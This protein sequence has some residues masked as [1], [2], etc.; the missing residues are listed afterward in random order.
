MA[1]FGV[2]SKIVLIS[3]GTEAAEQPLA[4]PQHHSETKTNKPFGLMVQKQIQNLIQTLDGEE[5]TCDEKLLIHILDLT[6]GVLLIAHTLEDMV[7][8]N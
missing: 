4:C 8:S 3:F 6:W 7:F 5:N 2:L 1:G